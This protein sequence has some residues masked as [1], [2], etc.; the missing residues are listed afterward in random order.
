MS[1]QISSES[2]LITGS[3]RGIGRGIALRLAE[4]GVKK[5][6][7]HYYQNEDAANETMKLIRERGA[8][9]TI[10]QADVARLE[11]IKRMFATIRSEFGGL[12]IF[13]NNARAELEHFYE[14]TLKLPVEK[15][16]HAIDSQARAFLVSV[17]EAADMMPD[18]AGRIVAITYA[19]G[20]VTGTWQSWAAM[21]PAKAA[22]E[23][24]CRYF[25]SALADRGITVNSVS[26]G[27]TDDSVLNGLPPEVFKMIKDHH[28]SGWTPMKRLTTPR[29]VG[30]AVSLLCSEEAGFITGQLLYV[31]GGGSIA[32]PDFPL[33]IQAG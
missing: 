29:D 26:P 13:V 27:A 12:G 24:L 14:P 28:E 31:D 6:A 33:P 30:N 5:I 3:S 23:S 16:E 17:R 10:V 9:G 15:F 8:N 20:S 21:G 11:D 4:C 19:P 1:V 18:K 2:A 7:V 25:A 32:L 22:L